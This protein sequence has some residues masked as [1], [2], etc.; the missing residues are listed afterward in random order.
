MTVRIVI[1]ETFKE[2]PGT[3]ETARVETAR[4]TKAARTNVENIIAA[5]KDW[6]DQVVH[7]TKMVAT[8]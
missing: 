1:P 3:A 2:R 4:K 8:F 5:G 6:V 7:N